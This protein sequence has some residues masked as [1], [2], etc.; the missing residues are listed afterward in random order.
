[1]SG[2]IRPAAEIREGSESS[3]SIIV[4]TM[5]RR[6]EVLALLSG[7]ARVRKAQGD[8]VVVVD[9]GSTDGTC[10]AVQRLH[11]EVLFLRHE[12]NRGAPAARNAGAAASSGNVLIFLDDD[13]RVEDP[14]FLDRVR[15]AFR[16]DQ[17]MGVAAFMILD[18]ASR[19]PRSFEI[20]RKLKET[21]TE[22]FETSHFIAAGCAVRREV[23]QAVGGMDE[24]L[25]YGFEE[26]DFSYRAVAAGFR[27][28]YRPEIRMLHNLSGAGRPQGRKIYYF[29][30]NKIWISARYLPWRMV[31]VQALLWSAYGLK[32]SLRIGRPDIFLKG[33]A[34]GLLGIPRRMGFRRKD[35]L[36][37]RVLARLRKIEGRLYY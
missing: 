36:P 16:A 30:R 3:I 24:T 27:I 34:A 7:L 32:E 19:R 10:E 31:L 22:P 23:Y 4:V 35:R 37:A 9:N 1:M 5:N 20:P 18:P 12:A 2:Q 29:C 11:P 13:S 17:L 28:I 15:T 26:L 33:L 6:G 25:Q 14:A 8:Q 21:P